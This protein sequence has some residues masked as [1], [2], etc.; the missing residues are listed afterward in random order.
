MAI[1]WYTANGGR[2]SAGKEFNINKKHT[3]RNNE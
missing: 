1:C 2:S 3:R